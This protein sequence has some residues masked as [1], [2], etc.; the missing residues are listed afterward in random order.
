MTRKTAAAL[1]LPLAGA[2]LTACFGAS[3]DITVR[4]DGSGRIIS[5][6][7]VSRA[8]EAMGRLD[9][10]EGWPVIP[11][12]RADLERTVARIPGLRL[13]SFSS[14]EVPSA[15]IGGSD[16]RIRAV[17]DFDDLSALVAFL[18][19]S[20][21]RASISREGSANV[22]RLTLL[23]PFDPIGSAELLALMGEVF[24]GYEMSVRLNA[25]GNPAVGVFPAVPAGARIE[26]GGGSALFAVAVGDLPAVSDGLVLEFSW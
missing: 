17:L 21:S 19:S 20:G 26:T 8:F 24:E 22:L 7:R 2:L 25:P 18:D 3:I 4:A 10:N 12:G 13:S 5:E 6:Y 23:E 11:A 9:G 14:R 16:T 15:G 1:L